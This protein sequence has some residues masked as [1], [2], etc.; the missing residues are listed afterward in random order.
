M[1]AR[2]PRRAADHVVLTDGG[3]IR[4]LHCAGRENMFPASGEGI[5]LSDVS[6]FGKSFTA[7]HKGCA[8][9]TGT[10][11][12]WCSSTEHGHDQHVTVAVERPEDWPSCGDTGTSARAIFLHMQG[13]R[14]EEIGDNIPHDPDDFGRCSRLLTAPWA[15][16]WRARMGEMARYPGWTK[17]SSAWAELEAL[18]REELTTGAAPKLYARL[19]LARGET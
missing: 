5:P 13:L 10:F 17:L 15:S 14:V 4:C 6:S 9:P 2:K 1:A 18:Y 11:C 7:K 16:T 3:T 19:R 8:K 12:F